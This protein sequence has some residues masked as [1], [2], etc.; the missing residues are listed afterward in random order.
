MSKSIVVYPMDCAG[1]RN[2]E[3]VCSLVHFGVCSPELSNIR[4]V[5]WQ[6]KGLTVPFTCLQC[7]DPACMEACPARA[8]SRDEKTGAVLVDDKL[9]LG[10]KMCLLV[11]PFGGPRVNRETS[12]IIK[13]DLCGGDPQC[14]KNCPTKAICF[15]DINEFSMEKKKSSATVMVKDNL[16]M[17]EEIAKQGK[18]GASCE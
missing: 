5:E 8:I 6:D 11:C 1:C 4:V 9:C 7:E 12:T 13:C 17:L 10:C 3:V 2:C 16:K 18:G 15:M 14:V